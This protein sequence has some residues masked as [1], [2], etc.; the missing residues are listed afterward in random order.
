MDVITQTKKKNL[1][2]DASVF[3]QIMGC[4]RKTDYRYNLN[5]E[6]INGKSNNLETGSMMHKILEVFNINTINGFN[7]T[8]SIQNG[9]AAGLM[10]AL[11]C[12]HCTRFEPI[13]NHEENLDCNDSCIL[14]P[15][16]KHKIDE[17][18][19]LVNTPPDNTTKPDRIGYNYVLDTANQYFEFWKNDF[20]IPKEA[21]SVKGKMLYED[22]NIRIYWKAKIDTL[23]D[24]NDNSGKLYSKDYKTMK[25]NRDTVSLNNQFMGQ[26]FVTEQRKVFID[27]IGFQTSLKPEQKFSRP[28]VQYT[29]DALI[30]WQSEIVPYWAYQ[31]LSWFESGYFPPNFD[32]CETKF[33]K[34]EFISAC[35][36]DKILREEE[37]KR[38]FIVGKPW[39][40]S[41]D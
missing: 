37:L 4:G 39:D 40:P 33:G 26:C 23:V 5:L 20:W 12:R 30:E 25:Q 36:A 2:F 38:L 10:Y 22:D 7:R 8:T 17:Y 15:S 28:P 19:G 9:L 16:C 18:P 27:K 1:V 34:C 31:Y 13:H 3:S 41:N 6:P 11:G 32:H 29:T 24:I 14:V 21:E 35:E